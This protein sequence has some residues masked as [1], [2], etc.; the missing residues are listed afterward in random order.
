[1]PGRPRAEPSLCMDALVLTVRDRQ[2][3][4][5]VPEA[6][7]RHQ[8][9]ANVAAVA[10]RFVPAGLDWAGLEA[11][12]RLR[13]ELMEAHGAPL[14]ADDRDAA[15]AA[16]HPQA[17]TGTGV[18][19]GASSLVQGVSADSAPDQAAIPAQMTEE[20]DSMCS[21]PTDL[22]ERCRRIA[23]SDGLCSYHSRRS[24]SAGVMD[25]LDLINWDSDTEALRA[26]SE[27]A[28]RPAP[29]DGCHVEA[30]MGESEVLSPT[31]P[32]EA[33]EAAAPPDADLAAELK[34]A[35][36]LRVVS[37]P[38]AP[39]GESGR[40][41]W[42]FEPPDM[43]ALDRERALVREAVPNASE[44]VIDSAVEIHRNHLSAHTVRSYEQRLRGFFEYAAANGFNP[45]TCEPA[46]VKGYITERMY[47]GKPGSSKGGSGESEPYSRS[48][49]T[50]FVS[51]LRCA[52]S[53]R[54]LPDHTAGLNL[55]KTMRGYS[56]LK[57]SELPRM[58]KSEIRPNDLIEI[59]R[60]ARLGCTYPAA[61]LRAAIAIGCDP[62]LDFSV[63]QL[64]ALTFKDVVVS[65]ATATIAASR[66]PVGAIEIPER[67]GDPACPVAA[68]RSLREATR[69]HMRAQRGGSTPTDAQL[70]DEHLF[71]NKNTGAPLSRKGLRLIVG[72]A[73]AG[74]QELAPPDRGRL[75]PLGPRQRRQAM[76]AD[77]DT[78]TVRDLAMIFHTAFCSA[79][80]GNV[81]D[82]NVEHVEVWGRDVDGASVTTPLVDRVERD[83]SVTKGILSRIAVITPTDILDENGNSL[84]G[85]LIMGIHTT[86]AY[87]TKTQ[88]FH[89]NWYP[90]QPGWEACPVRLLLKWLKAYDQLLA[91]DSGTRLAGWHPLFSS[92]KHP[93]EPIN[94]LSRT[95]GKA[96]KTSMARIGRPPEAYSAHSLR[97]FR[98]SH[99]LSQG[100]SMTDVMV[101][102]GR[103]SEVE[104]IVYARRDQRDPFAADLMVGLY[105]GAT[106]RSDATMSESR[107]HRHDRCGVTAPDTAG[108]AAAVQPSRG[109]KPSPAAD[110]GAL[111]KAV[112]AFR[113]VVE[114]LREAGLDDRD[115]AAAARLDLA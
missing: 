55:N 35:R 4:G 40:Q 103:S 66:G 64:C 79:R 32:D 14:Q 50:S 74:L 33:A 96:V 90:A 108:A 23:D 6:G 82:F 21:A 53:A 48:Y 57:G 69:N 27:G 94:T 83:G 30:S 11:L 85:S 87:G 8:A 71:T 104:G 86:F 13:P 52:T 76:T 70:H 80:A 105:S 110:S 9:R 15:C 2:H 88:R 75:A 101:H 95:L 84:Y 22:G 28:D 24:R 10:D 3:G 72:K 68:L 65:G 98:A 38:D 73:C 111:T 77:A 47:A 61:Q 78:T 60:T 36:H 93:G 59:E 1:M 81:G 16:N 26:M 46:Q 109:G 114:H 107:D 89:A 43:L 29:G 54:G 7:A 113:D 49:F 19:P 12:G 62:G 99:V 45:L 102:D 17:P 37:E 20:F 58:A 67:P 63:S 56:R 92:L 100:G 44:A 41:G 42:A 31:A 39:D 97:K 5:P 18:E 91:A 51:A 106:R 115:I 34:R 25:P 112:C